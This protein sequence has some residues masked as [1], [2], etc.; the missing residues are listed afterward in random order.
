MLQYNAKQ[1]LILILKK[2]LF[3]M[4]VT[5]VIL[6]QR[7]GN[8]VNKI[9]LIFWPLNNRFGLFLAS[10]ALFGFLLKV[11]SGNSAPDLNIDRIWVDDEMDADFAHLT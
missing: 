5:C 2:N 7:L 8:T 11:S 9:W 1:D 4:L 3:H 10:L 6:W